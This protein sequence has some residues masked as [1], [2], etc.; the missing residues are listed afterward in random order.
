VSYGSGPR[1]STEV[2]SNAATCP[3]TL[4][5]T[6]QL[7]WAPALPHVLW[8]QT[9]PLTRGEL[10]CCHMSYDSGPRLPDEVGSSAAVCP[11]ALDLTYRLRW[12]LTLPHILWLRTSPPDW[13]GLRRC[14]VSH[15]S[16][17]ATCFKHKESLADLPMQLGT[18]VPNARAHVFKAPHIRAIMRLQD[19]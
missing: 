9:S 2:G 5:L 17:W 1:L 6:S 18:H 7:R 10:W 13:G 11:I 8:L 3:M 16:L 12:T 15:D 4:D 19:V 14:H